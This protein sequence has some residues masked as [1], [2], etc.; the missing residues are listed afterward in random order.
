MN[1]HVTLFAVKKPTKGLC[2]QEAYQG[3]S[4][5]SQLSHLISGE[6]TRSEKCRQE[7]KQYNKTGVCRGIP[8]FLIL[9]HNIDCEAALTSAY[10]LCFGA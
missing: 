10:N 4:L 2:R 7:A 8:F 3:S 6:V 1:T 9:I 5:P